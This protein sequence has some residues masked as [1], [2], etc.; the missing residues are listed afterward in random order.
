MLYVEDMAYERTHCIW[1]GKK[2]FKDKF[3]DKVMGQVEK[4]A[5]NFFMKILKF[6]F[7]EFML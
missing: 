2:G 4:T 1:C 7:Y 3:K 5:G 6:A